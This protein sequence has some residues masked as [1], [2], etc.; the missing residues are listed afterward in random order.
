LCEVA[1]QPPEVSGNL[2]WHIKLF[3]LY[4]VSVS[5]TKVQKLHKEDRSVTGLN[6]LIYRLSRMT[7]ALC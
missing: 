6:Q 2:K 1:D 7:Q 4:E 3:P 5:E